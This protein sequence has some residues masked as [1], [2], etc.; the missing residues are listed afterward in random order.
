MSYEEFL[1][2]VK[3]EITKRVPKSSQVMLNTVMKNN[4]CKLDAI[5]I[6]DPEVTVTPNIYL[7]QYYEQYQSGSDLSSIAEI[8][9][10]LSKDRT[11]PEKEIIPDISDFNSIAHLITYRIVNWEK[12]LKRL[13]T[14]PYKDI[15]DLVVIY[16][17]IIKSDSDG[18]SSI[19]ITDTLMEKWFGVFIDQI[20][21]CANRNT[22]NLFPAIIRD[23][24]DVI[25]DMVIKNISD[26]NLEG[27]SQDDY[28]ELMNM[29]NTN[30]KTQDLYV[31]TNNRGINGASTLLYPNVLHDFA[32][33]INMNFYILLS[34]IHEC[35]LAPDNGKMNKAALKEM[36]KDVNDSQVPADEVLSDEV[37]YYDLSS[38][39]FHIISD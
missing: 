24:N 2:K 30:Q 11:E 13:R 4:D 9:I 26:N 37:Y 22:P 29:L 21:E 5:S 39:E 17:I 1:Q 31:L 15:E 34:S 8:I 7:N 14:M 10:K 36:V 20:D 23:M 6:V 16:S 19:P 33:K 28:H 35:I 38:D 3:H 27:I 25:K 18:I 32:A 12:N